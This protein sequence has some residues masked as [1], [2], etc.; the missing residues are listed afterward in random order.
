M[1]VDFRQMLATAMKLLLLCLVVGYVLS[2]IDFEPLGFVRFL[3][4]SL[5]NAA[6]LVAD[7]VRW[8]TPYVLLGAIVVVPV[9]LLRLAWRTLKKGGGR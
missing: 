3:S 6:E 9:Y 7:A 5:H 8:A 2:V 4:N 1:N